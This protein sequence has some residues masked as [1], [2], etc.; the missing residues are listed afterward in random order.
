MIEPHVNGGTP[1]LS[2]AKNA[3]SAKIMFNDMLGTTLGSI[4]N[5]KLSATSTTAF[6]AATD[7][8]QLSTDY[9]FYTGK[10]Q[11][12]GLG[13]VFLFRNYKPDLG[14]QSSPSATP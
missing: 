1:I 7:N 2:T 5:G 11:V 8:R 6:G 13:Y 10:P 14:N 4:E 3:K 12:E 9:R